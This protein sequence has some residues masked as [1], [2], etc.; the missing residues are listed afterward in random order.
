M[1]FRSD[2]LLK[3]AACWQM[4]TG[5]RDMTVDEVYMTDEILDWAMYYLSWADVCE[6]SASMATS[7]ACALG[8]D[9]TLSTT[10]P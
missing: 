7:E 9:V 5:R 6:V 4:R 2:A 10:P 3:A 1:L 8:Y